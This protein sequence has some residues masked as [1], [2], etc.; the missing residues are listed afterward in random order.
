V[1]YRKLN[2]N[3]I[4]KILVQWQKAGVTLDQLNEGRRNDDGNR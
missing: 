2:F 1:M 3:Y 4:D